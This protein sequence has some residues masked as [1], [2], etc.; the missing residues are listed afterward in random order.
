MG[1]PRVRYRPEMSEEPKRL[2][3]AREENMDIHKMGPKQYEIVSESGST[4][5][6]DLVA[7]ECTCNDYRTRDV[8]KCKH[9]YKGL[10]I[11]GELDE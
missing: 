4:Y 1:E 10:L 8:D 2:T 9:L 3:R 7:M 11:T 5:E 6:I